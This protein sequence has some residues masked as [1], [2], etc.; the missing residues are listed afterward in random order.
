MKISRKKIKLEYRK[1]LKDYHR[2]INNL[3][4]EDRSNGIE[5]AKMYYSYLAGAGIPYATLALDVIKNE[6]KFGKLAN[7]HLKSQSIFEGIPLD[8]ITAVKEKI[9]ISLASHDAKM[10]GDKDYNQNNPYYKEIEEYHIKVFKYHTSPYAWGGLALKELI[11][12]GSWMKFYEQDK[13]LFEGIKEIVKQ[14]K[15]GVSLEY[16]AE[17]MLKSV[18]HSHNQ[19]TFDGNAFFELK[20]SAASKEQAAL[21]WKID[22][23]RI[24][25]VEEDTS[26][27]D[28]VSSKVFKAKAAE[29]FV[30][31]GEFDYSSS[32]SEGE[33]EF[34]ETLSANSAI[35]K[36]LKQLLSNPSDLKQYNKESLSNAMQDLKLAE[37]FVPN[38]TKSAL[39]SMNEHYGFMQ[40]L[41][42]IK[43]PKQELEK[44][45]KSEQE[46]A[47]MMPVA[48]ELIQNISNQQVFT[49]GMQNFM[50]P[51]SNNDQT[52]E[53]KNDDPDWLNDILSHTQT[54]MNQAYNDPEM[55]QFMKDL[56][57]NSG[58]NYD[59]FS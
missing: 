27:F 5:Y 6:G 35:N 39:E 51:Q 58:F 4:S 18:A 19:Y 32:D 17:R 47:K 29:C 14:D 2:D 59:D 10:R 43:N 46:E 44:I 53:K 13:G 48:Q 49:A 11:G 55:Q 21:M 33:E 15:I 36:Q 52:Q 56:G 23:A 26:M 50:N 1:E 24:E 7:I 42:G 22:P 31:S 40:E 41:V 34:S 3:D 20:M 9:I 45:K 38:I 54:A 8:E 30:P 16:S 12:S 37:E 28:S 25:L 57:G